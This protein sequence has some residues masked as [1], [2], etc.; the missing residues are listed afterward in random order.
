MS[1]LRV[2]NIEAKANASSPTVDEKVKITDSQGRVLM[3][4]DG[5][6][7]GITTVG[8]NTTGNTFTVD[9]NSGVT[10]S[11]IVTATN[12]FSGNVTGNVTGNITGNINATGVSTIATLNVTQSN[13]TNLNVSGVTTTA[14]L[15]TTSIVGVTT[16]GITTA[17][18]GSVNDGPLS[19][20]RN[21]IINGDMR[22]DQRRNGSSLSLSNSNDNTLD[23]YLCMFQGGATG[24]LTFQR[25]GDAPVGF[26]SSM[27]AT[28]TVAD[29]TDTQAYIGQFIEGYNWSDMYYGTANAKTATL[30]FWVKS[31]IAG[32]YC[33]GITGG[34][35]SANQVGYV[36]EYTINSVNTWEYKTVTIPGE[37]SGSY[38]FD[39]TNGAGIR[40][41]FD[42]GTKGSTFV[43]AP[44]AWTA[45]L[46]FSTST[47][48]RVYWKENSGATFY[49][50][51]VQLEPGTVATPFE[52]RSFGQELALCQRYYEK[53]YD[54]GTSPGTN[55]FAGME[56]PSGFSNGSN[57]FVT[58]I[59]F[60]V[61]KRATPSVTAYTATG[62]SGSWNYSR[63]GA[64]GTA[65]TTIDNIGEA[66]CRIYLNIGAAWTGAQV[67]G[68]WVSAIELY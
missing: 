30:S 54:V 66:G 43:A 35:V 12:G 40:L 48:G 3:Q 26:T 34:G 11:G 23:R 15:R 45:N 37:T 17:Y 19:G 52:R 36:F 67:E 64:S 18:I 61:N 22:I 41:K 42:L 55:T 7:S 33:G 63:S 9:A 8:I 59:R 56:V 24:T 25:V 53:S 60:K 4:V 50:T 47:A 14:T 13:P 28:V 57:N 6:T 44:N 1:T 5:K 20:F 32:L 68:H 65:A 62:T 16:A 2:S 46:K 39:S 10:F 29:T 21:R 51:G 49:L 31:S 27:K 38:T 58:P